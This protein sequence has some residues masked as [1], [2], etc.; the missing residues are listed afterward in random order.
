MP[1]THSP[2]LR[3]SIYLMIAMVVFSAFGVTFIYLNGIQTKTA[4]Q[5]Q[6]AQPITVTTGSST[7][8]LIALPQINTATGSAT[9]IDT[10][11][12]PTTGEVMKVEASGSINIT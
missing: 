3:R 6:N 2:L 7:G 9:G 11:T 8:Q 1:R 12:M 4:L 10:K 5:V